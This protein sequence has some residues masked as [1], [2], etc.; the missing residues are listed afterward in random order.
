[1]TFMDARARRD[2]GFSLSELLVACL[3]LAVLAAIVVPVMLNQRRSA[4]D[5]RTAEAVRNLATFQAILVEQTNTGT[6]WS[7]G[8]PLPVSLAGY[9]PP[10]SATSL[11]SATNGT[12]W[13]VA[14]WATGGNRSTQEH[15]IWADS[16]S[17][18]VDMNRPDTPACAALTPIVV[19]PAGPPPAGGTFTK[20]VYSSG[21]VSFTNQWTVTGID[22]DLY[23]GGD[24][25]C[26]STVHIYGKVVAVGNAYMTNGCQVDQELWVGGTL[27]MD[28]GSH[29][30]GNA[31]AVGNV[32]MTSNAKVDGNLTTKGTVRFSATP[33]VGKTVYAG[34]TVRIDT[35]STKQVGQDIRTQATFSSNQDSLGRAAVQAIVAGGAIYEHITSPVT[36]GTPPPVTLPPAPYMPDQWVGFTQTSWTKVLN[37]N[38]AANTAPTWSQMRTSAPGCTVDSANYSLNGPLTI[39]TNTIIDAR[40][41]TTGCAR[42]TL[43]LMQLRMSADLTIYADSVQTTNGLTTVSTDGNQHILRVIIPGLAAECGSGRDILIGS[44]SMLDQKIQTLLYTPAHINIDGVTTIWGQIIGGCVSSTGQTTI[45]YQPVTLP[46][47]GG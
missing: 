34:G 27:T 6:N 41:V 12:E 4:V 45:N 20:A 10:D 40:Q 26:N 28:S 44:G 14:G 32:S 18:A 33:W 23:V 8:T 9:Q 39:T 13:C 3:I 42:I 31:Q 7:T 30:L 46:G 11:V 5:A 38:A 29:I 35:A 1:M 16:T 36:V 22:A 19:P 24:F 2:A 47:W 17:R 25:N 43:Q 15:P 37:D 21:S